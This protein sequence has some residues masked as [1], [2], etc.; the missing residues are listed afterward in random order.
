MEKKTQALGLF[1]LVFPILLASQSLLA[2][3]N[4]AKLGSQPDFLRAGKKNFVFTTITQG[5][6]PELYI[7][8]GTVEGTRLV[9]GSRLTRSGGGS[10]RHWQGFAQF[11]Q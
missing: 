3:I 9:V 8:D 2:D 6:R 10:S 11:V 5:N 1:M 7:S 4:P